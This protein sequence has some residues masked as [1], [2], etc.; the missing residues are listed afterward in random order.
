MQTFW[1]SAGEVRPLAALHGRLV[2]PPDTRWRARLYARLLVAIVAIVATVSGCDD[3]DDE[4]PG[5]ARSDASAGDAVAVSR[6]ALSLENFTVQPV[7]AY[8]VAIK[9]RSAYGGAALRVRRASDNA[10]SD[11]GFTGAGRV[12]GTS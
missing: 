4:R 12:D 9:L 7:A 2:V 3:A 10:E 5:Q 6:S 8:S 1:E 11:V